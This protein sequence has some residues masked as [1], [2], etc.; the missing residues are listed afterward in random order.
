MGHFTVYLALFLVLFS[1]P[2]GLE[3]FKVKAA[4]PCNHIHQELSSCA[5][6]VAGDGA[7]PLKSCCQGMRDRDHT[8]VW[9]KSQWQRI[10][11]RMLCVSSFPHRLCQLMVTS[12]LLFLRNVGWWALLCLLSVQTSIA[13]SKL[14]PII[15]VVPLFWTCP[16]YG[17]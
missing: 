11:L 9:R 3:K 1:H 5:S 7:S 17:L 8:R 2:N 6:Y 12:S 16:M 4:V 10:S 15:Y 14:P 13:P